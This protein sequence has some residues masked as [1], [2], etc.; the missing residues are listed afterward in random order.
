VSAP[1]PDFPSRN[2]RHTCKPSGCSSSSSQLMDSAE[3]RMNPFP[4]DGT[5]AT[6]CAGPHVGMVTVSGPVIIDTT[7]PLVCDAA[8]GECRGKTCPAAPLGFTTFARYCPELVGVCRGLHDDGHGSDR[9]NGKR[10][11][12]VATRADCQAFCDATMACVG[13]TYFAR[14]GTTACNLYGPGL[15]HDLGGSWT[16]STNPTTTIGGADGYSGYVCVAVA[17]RN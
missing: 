9:V 3:E 16:A 1:R 7:G 8:S 17:G 5:L 11:R 14:T 6:G 2:R 12:G 4:C 15:D 13:Y 10:Q